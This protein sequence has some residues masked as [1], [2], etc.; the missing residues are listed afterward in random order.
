MRHCRYGFVTY[1]GL[2]DTRSTLH[3]SSR[4]ILLWLTLLLCVNGMIEMSAAH[5]Q[6]ENGMLIIYF[7]KQPQQWRYEYIPVASKTRV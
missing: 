1:S 7:A 4:P 3:V 6:M 5:C 2:T